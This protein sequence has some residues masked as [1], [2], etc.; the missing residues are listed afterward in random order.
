[1]YHQQ[2]S[3]DIVEDTVMEN[4]ERVLRLKAELSG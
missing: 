2:D 3:I 1:M 4:Y